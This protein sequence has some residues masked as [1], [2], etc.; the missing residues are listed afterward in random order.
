M[1]HP[2]VSQ[3]SARRYLP[4]PA[5]VLEGLALVMMIAAVLSLS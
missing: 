5:H 4:L 3:G 1:T 2:L